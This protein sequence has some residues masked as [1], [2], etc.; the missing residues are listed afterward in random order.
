PYGAAL[1][2]PAPRTEG[3]R[4]P[5]RTAGAYVV[6]AGGEPVVYLERGGRALQTL[7]D[8]GDGRLQPALAA[9]VEHVRG[10]RIK[11]LGLERVDGESAMSSPL[12]PLLTE[13]GFQEGPRRL[14]LTA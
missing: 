12:A 9:L 3:A 2:W 4:R 13:L 8:R 5:A 1:K 14:T 6:L 10:G 11:R 7:V